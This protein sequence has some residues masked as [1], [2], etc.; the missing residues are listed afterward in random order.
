MK[1][2]PSDPIA[3]TMPAALSEVR[4]L[5]ED[6]EKN[7]ALAS[8]KLAKLVPSGDKKRGSIGVPDVDMNGQIKEPEVESTKKDGEEGSCADGEY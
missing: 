5:D 7:H 1:V 8:E 2:T 6:Q 3:D 4:D